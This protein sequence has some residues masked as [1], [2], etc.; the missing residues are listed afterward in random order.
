MAISL[1]NG[2]FTLHQ[3]LSHAAG[4]GQRGQGFTLRVSCQ[5]HTPSAEGILPLHVD[6]KE[7]METHGQGPLPTRCPAL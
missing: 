1:N 5:N 2:T 3:S 6:R 7:V 4:E